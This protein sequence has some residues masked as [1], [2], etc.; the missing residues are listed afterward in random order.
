[1]DMKKLIYLWKWISNL[2]VIDIPEQEKR[3]LIILNRINFFVIIV[4]MLGFI[5]TFLNYGLMNGSKPGIGSFRLFLIMISGMISFLLM[6]FRWYYAAKIITS[7]VPAFLLI[8]FPTLLGDIKIEYYFYYPY[9]GTAL[10]MIPIML[11]PLKNERPILILLVLFCFLLTISSDNLLTLFSVSEKTPEVLKER[12][13]YYKLSQVLLFLFIVITVFTL[14]DINTKYETILSEQNS[15]LIAQKE[16]LSAQS[17]KLLTINEELK[18]LNQDLEGHKNHLEE[19]VESRTSAFRESESRFHNLFENA[20]DAI[21]LMKEDVFVDCNLKT[22][23]I[24]GC[25]KEHIIGMTPVMFSPRLQP[26]G[27]DSKE[28]ATG[29]INAALKGSPQR[30]E[31]QH[32]KLDGSLFDAEVSLN[33]IELNGQFFLLA[34]VRDVTQKKKTVN[35]LIESERKVRAIFDL[36]LPFLG[37]LSAEGNLIEANRTSLEFA[38]IQLADVYGKPFWET[39]W[40]SHSTL[41]QERVRSAIDAARNG[42]EVQFEAIHLAQNGAEHYFIFTL[43][44]VFDEHGKVVLLIPNAFDI[45]ARRK[46]EEALIKSEEKFNKAFNLSPNMISIANLTQGDKIIEIN[47]TYE[48]KT[49]FKRSEILGRTAIELGI[50]DSQLYNELREILTTDKSIRDFEFEFRN[51]SG[52]VGIGLLSV[53]LILLNNEEYSLTTVVD[54][55]E[56]KRAEVALSDSEKKFRSIFDKSKN[57]I[58]IL[59]FDMRVLAANRAATELSGHELGDNPLYAGDFILPDQTSDLTERITL[60]AKGENLPPFEYKSKFKDGYVHIVEAESSVMDY[61]GQKAILVILRDVTQIREAE[62]KVLEAVINTE[63]NER[64]RIAQDLHDGLGPVLSAIK[65]FFQV[66]QDTTDENKKIVLSEKLKNT[67]EEAVKGISEI[68]HN[69]SPHV[70]KNYGFYTALKQF[71]HQITLTNLINIH[72]DCG[73]ELELNQ[74]TGITLYRAISELINNSIKHSGCKNIS[75]TIYPNTGFIQIDYSDDGKGF[76]VTSLIDRP[77]LGSGVQNIRNRLNALQGSIEMTST[78]GRGMHAL[79]KIPV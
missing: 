19:L 14:K 28:N 7:V 1:M 40:W 39:P 58:I 32:N 35:A 78:K 45:T 59:G 54:I 49:G 38:G 46:A 42:R 79:L 25:S 23:E 5:A 65:L 76:D 64:M 63:E 61:Y 66:Y 51:K 73:E 27:S 22:T 74:N 6:A 30:F 48:L 31:W 41:L 77:S 70:L 8:L 68:S 60:L 72:L 12:Y 75:I 36:S 67:I 56:R 69:I 2:R 33:S 11:F 47:N 55:T 37:L 50:L 71:I 21:F 17:E 44:P 53:D 9:A 43:T 15:I 16:E 4:S 18:M 20:N 26:D 62:H 10:A 24:F 57:G 13:F 34:I 29:K 52:E 3:S